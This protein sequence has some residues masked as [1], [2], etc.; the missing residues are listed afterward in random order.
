MSIGEEQ[1]Y[2]CM[3][4]IVELC[5]SRPLGWLVDAR[6]QQQFDR[7][8]GKHSASPMWWCTVIQS[9]CVLFPTPL[10]RV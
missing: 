5:L 1:M 10:G 3:K 4:A 7:S 6:R 2:T 9:T 8:R